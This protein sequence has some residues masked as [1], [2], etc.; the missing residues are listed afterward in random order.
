[1]APSTRRTARAPPSLGW[2]SSLRRTFASTPRPGLRTDVEA[3][4][5]SKH[6]DGQD[7]EAAD[8]ED[9]FANLV[10]F[11]PEERAQVKMA[12]RFGK[13]MMC[14]VILACVGFV[15]AG[16]IDFQ[17]RTKLPTARLVNRHLQ[18]GAPILGRLAA[19]LLR[20]GSH[21]TLSQA[22]TEASKDRERRG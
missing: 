11:L 14:L 17:R 7:V 3:I 10:E 15:V 1:M 20:S 13:F 19:F 8:D 5:L 12:A 21:A 16:P 9:P 18:D 2:W 6:V 4:P 22:P